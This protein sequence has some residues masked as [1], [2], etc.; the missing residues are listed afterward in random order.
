MWGCR[1]RGRRCNGQ[2]CVEMQGEPV[3]AVGELQGQGMVGGGAH[4]AVVK[5]VGHVNCTAGRGVTTSVLS[6]S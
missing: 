3:C 1:E 2:Q 5:G 4:R 6:Q